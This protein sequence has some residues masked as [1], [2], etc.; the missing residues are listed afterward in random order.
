MKNKDLC[1]LV[2]S[3]NRPGFLKQTLESIEKRLEGIS[4][5]VFVVDNGSDWE[6]TELIRQSEFLSGYL[7]LHK[8][9]GIN[10][11]IERFLLPS[12]VKRYEAILIS[13]ADMEYQLPLSI[14]VETLQLD[15]EI[16]AVSY[17]HSPEHA[18]SKKKRIGQHEFFL[19]D[20]ERGCSLLM[21]TLFLESLKPLPVE[22]M[23]DFDWWVC[24]DA[25]HSIQS[26]QKKIAVLPGGALHLGWKAGES[27][28]QTSEIAEYPNIR[29]G[30]ATT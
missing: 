28:W 23:K 7:L 14:G 17:Q 13:D 9:L 6:T 20:S 8:N 1:I 22:N 5:D 4:A 24:R 18:F 26:Q 11:A 25:P 19:K 30:L 21:K 10:G 16:K 2:I 27:T 12:L 3:W 29:E 15:S